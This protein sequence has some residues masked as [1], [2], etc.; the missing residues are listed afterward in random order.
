MEKLQETSIKNLTEFSA[1]L[2]LTANIYNKPTVH[3]FKQALNLCT[4]L[5][6][7]KSHVREPRH[8]L[9]TARCNREGNFMD[10]RI[11]FWKHLQ[12]IFLNT[13]LQKAFLNILFRFLLKWNFL[14]RQINESCY[15]IFIHLVLNGIQI[16]TFMLIL[17]FTLPSMTKCW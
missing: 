17:R 4:G 15:N 16:R 12:Q 5:E 14:K 13:K 7:A 1:C 11:L 6:G 3:L 10:F 8:A 2:R 9:R